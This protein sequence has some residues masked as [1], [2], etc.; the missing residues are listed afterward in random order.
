MSQLLAG[1]AV[2][3]GVGM[4][5]SPL[6]Q[7][8]LIL[9]ERHSEEVSQGFL[10]VITIGACAWLAHGI[11]SKNLIL[12]IPNGCGFICALTTLVAAHRFRNGDPRPRKSNR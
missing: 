12:I 2:T 10:L 4:A 1:L 3:M 11:D 7:L 8:R 5:L 9:K 6:L